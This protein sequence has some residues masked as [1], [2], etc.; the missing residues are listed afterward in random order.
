[1]M[2]RIYHVRFS[3]V[4]RPFVAKCHRGAAAA[5]IVC[6][7]V[8]MKQFRELG[9]ILLLTAAIFTPAMLSA[10]APAAPGGFPD[11]VGALKATPGVLGVDAAQT[12]SGKQVIFAW[13]ENKQAVLNWYNSDVHR[14]LMN[15]FSSGPRRPDG[16]LAGIKDDSGPVLAIASLTIDRAAMQRGDLKAGTTQIAIELYAPLPGGL[17]A[18]GRFAPASMKVPGLI[19]VPMSAPP[20]RDKH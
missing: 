10:Q 7:E 17:A 11:L 12:M 1:M 13:F 8:R 4:F 9:A 3:A 2:A 15:G 14:K 6:M 16:P 5:R 19:E 20:S 18:G